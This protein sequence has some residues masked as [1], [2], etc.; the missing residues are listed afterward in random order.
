MAPINIRKPYPLMVQDR[1]KD[2]PDRTFAIIPK[3]D[4]IEDG[5]MNLTYSQLDRAVNKMSWWLETQLGKSKNFDTIAYMGT[6]DHR[7]TFL[8][9]A[10][11]KTRRQA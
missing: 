1:A 7:Y 5:Y 9:L 8:Y 10:V 6:S 2:T 3:T 4:S 11:M